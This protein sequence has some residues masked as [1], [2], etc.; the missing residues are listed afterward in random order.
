[1]AIYEYVC[2]RDG[3]REA[4]WPLGTAPESV[5]CDVCG[6]VARRVFSAPALPFSSPLSRDLVATMDRAERSRVEPDVV[7]SL[8]PRSPRARTPTAPLTPALR[9]LPR[10]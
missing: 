6:E 3:V 5:P 4:T 8:P 10:P 9:R 1:M 7:G 2:E